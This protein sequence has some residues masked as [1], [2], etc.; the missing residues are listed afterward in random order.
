MGAAEERIIENNRLFREANEKIRAASGEF[1][2]PVEPIPFLCECP[3]ES[4]TTIVRLTADEYGSIRAN[5]RQYFTAAGH[6]PAEEPVGSV[7]ARHDGY[8]VIVKSL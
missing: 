1:D 7:V 5:D 2:Y 4:C 3:E 6:E 8:V